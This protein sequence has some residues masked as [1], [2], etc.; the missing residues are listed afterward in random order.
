MSI[1]EPLTILKQERLG[2]FVPQRL[3]RLETA[4]REGQPVH[5]V[6]QA[7]WDLAL[8]LGRQSLA[9]WLGSHGSGE[10]GP[11]AT[12]PD[13]RA[14]RR[15]AEL[16]PRC[17][18]T[19]TIT[20]LGDTNRYEVHRSLRT[21]RSR[22]VPC[23]NPPERD[24]PPSLSVVGLLRLPARHGGPCSANPPCYSPHAGPNGG[25]LCRR[26]TRQGITR[27][28]VY[29]MVLHQGGPQPR[30]GSGALSLPPFGHPSHASENARGHH[31]TR[32]CHASA[33]AHLSVF[34]NSCSR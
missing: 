7:I 16:H 34:S 3:Q 24:N 11:T 6:E 8:Q 27:P 33:K 12:L 2:K 23:A 10:L 15:L 25:G 19:R 9:A 5:E 29:R 31:A 4:L 14:A 21:I 32:S 1:A 13:G 17:Q 20:R 26:A 28:T 30:S 18:G 22:V